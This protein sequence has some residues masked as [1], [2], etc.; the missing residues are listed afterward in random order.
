M[1]GSEME[2]RFVEC[3]EHAEPLIRST[4]RKYVSLL[5]KASSDTQDDIVQEVAV[6]MLLLYRDGKVTDSGMFTAYAIRVASWTVLDRLRKRSITPRQYLAERK[7]FPAELDPATVTSAR[8]FAEMF[9]ALVDTL[10]ARQK[11]VFEAKT[12][13]LSDAE[14][15]SKLQIAP[16]TVRSLNRFAKEKL[17]REIRESDN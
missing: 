5:A 3:W 4:T 15:A 13:G 7:L 9:A 14:I 16:S 8:E 11:L 12:E 17:A 1:S 6:R 10:P 2:K